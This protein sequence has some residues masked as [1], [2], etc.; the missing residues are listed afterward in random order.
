MLPLPPQQWAEHTFECAELGDKRRTKRLTQVAA[1]LAAHTGSS[2]A[3][4]CE[5]NLALVEGAYR[6]IENEAVEP[7]AIAEAGFQATALAANDA[8]LLLAIEDST[9]LSYTHSTRSELGN[10]GESKN[11]KSRGIWAHSVMLIDADTER[12]VGLIDQQRWIRDDEERDKRSARK[13]RPY[14]EKESFKWQQSSENI[15]HRLGAQMTKVASVCDR[16]A[17]VYEYIQYKLTHNQRFVV[18]ATQNRILIDHDLLLFD[19]LAEEPALGTYTI[20]VPQR[21]GRNARK[22]RK[23]TLEVKKKTAT[24]Q[25]PQRPGGRLAPITVNVLIAEE[26]NNDTEDRLRWILLTSESVETFKNCRTVLRFYELRWRIEEFHKAWKTG[27]GVER[28][29]MLS[30][31]NMQRLAVILMFVAVRL[32]QIREALILPYDRKAKGG[33]TWNEKTPA[34]KVVSDEEWKVLWITYYEGKALPKKVPTLAWLLQTI[35]KVG[36][37]CDSKRTGI[38]GWLVVWEGWA[39]LQDRLH[40][41]RVTKGV[42]I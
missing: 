14:E 17:D 38:P 23:V 30:A 41:Y 27:T 2:L 42:E 13:Q 12:T 19:A 37:W 10:I 36:G 26:I 18:R 32:L 40:T 8:Q 7:D 35:A 3:S 15:K 39:K 4:S 25:S 1:E 21:G 28:L 33:K 24:I 16:E 20:K 11:S 5:G 34:N 6:L 31:G 29:R 9:T 22:A